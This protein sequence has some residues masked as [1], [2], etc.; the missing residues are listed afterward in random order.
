MAGEEFEEFN[1]RSQEPE[2]RSQEASAVERASLA[3]PTAIVRHF[4]RVR[5]ETRVS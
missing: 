1:E 4:T 3:R 5:L 2:S